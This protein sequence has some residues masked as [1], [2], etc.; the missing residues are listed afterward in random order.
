[1][2][3]LGHIAVGMA[4][5][6]IYRAGQPA[7]GSPVASAAAWSALSMLPDADTIGFAFG[8]RYADAWGHR[9]ATHSLA[10]SLA[11]GVVI[12]S[13]AHWTAMRVLA[14]TLDPLH[15][16]RIAVP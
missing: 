3:S 9:G 8:V 16:N 6:R 10:F 11:L 4:A 15:G 7:S 2:A 12:G 14:R 1:M 5:S 13:V